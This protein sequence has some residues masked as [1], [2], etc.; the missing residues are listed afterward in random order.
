MLGTP[1][2]EAFRTLN[3]VVPLVAVS[4]YYVIASMYGTNK[5]FL[6]NDSLPNILY[7]FFFWLVG[8]GLMKIAIE[9]QTI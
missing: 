8:R 9:S 4:N 7:D 3:T 5:A 6:M 1:Q 2:P